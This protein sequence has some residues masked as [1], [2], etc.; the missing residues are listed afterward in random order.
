VW[1]Y[2]ALE[3]GVVFLPVTVVMLVASLTAAALV[4]RV[5]ARPL[6]LAGGVA[7]IGGLYWLS[8]VTEHGTY[9]GG[10]LGPGL[11]TGIAFGLLI[12]PATLFGLS[13]VPEADSGA[14]GG[15]LNAGRQIGGSIGLAVLGTVAW[16]VVANSARAQAAAR[17][18]ARV[19]AA[20]QRA[21]YQ[22]ALAVGF[23]R[24]F[25]VAAAIAAA[26]L[27]VAITAIRVRRADLAGR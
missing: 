5:G 4:P 9:V 27:V 2:S 3:T 18:A 15:L 17:G 10:L 19:S 12:V 26:I 8:R 21:A 11:V 6:L 13:R 16:T 22:H 1:G 7:V 24:A 20:G 25:L 23:D 14:A